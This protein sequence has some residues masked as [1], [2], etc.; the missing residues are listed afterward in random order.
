MISVQDNTEKIIVPCS[1]IGELKY[2][3]NCPIS[4]LIKENRGIVFYPKLFDIKNS[5]QRIENNHIFDYYEKHNHL[6][7]VYLSTNN[8]VGIIS[9]GESTLKIHSRFDEG[10]KDFFLYYLFSKVF[11]INILDSNISFVKNNIF[12]ILAYMFPKYLS[13]AMGQGLYKEYV[14]RYNNDMKI[15]GRID[16]N[17]FIKC[18]IPFH[19]KVSYVS[20]D[21]FI[22]NKLN[23]LIRHTIEFLKQKNILEVLKYGNKDFND[24]VNLIY[25]ITQDYNMNDRKRVILNNIIKTLN[26]P[27]YY[28]HKKLQQLCI[29]ILTNCGVV[30]SDDNNF[31]YGFLIDISWLFE[32]YLFVLL[33]KLNFKHSLNRLHINGMTYFDNKN[34]RMKIYPDFYIANKIVCDAKYKKN[35]WLSTDVHQMASY[36][37]RLKL[38]KALLI[39]PKY[40]GGSNIELRKI[41]DIDKV[42]GTA[43]INLPVN[44]NSYKDFVNKM[45][46]SENKFLQTIEDYINK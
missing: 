14:Y 42:I 20:R 36:M 45:H 5:E 18:D 2:L 28:N 23:Q 6:N 11:K 29:D 19:G 4:E 46:E 10:G 12:N 3:G 27:Y 15:N 37:L 35:V 25:Q 34:A 31:A 8:L 17:K 39:K 7:N 43:F 44:C 16:L 24:N 32:E 41:K 1:D 40:Q 22:D 30:Y 21:Y 13:D 38:D 9:K 33:K 26:H